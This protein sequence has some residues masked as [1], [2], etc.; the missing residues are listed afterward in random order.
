MATDCAGEQARLWVAERARTPFRTPRA[1]TRQPGS[2][3]IWIPVWVRIPNR[4]PLDFDQNPNRITLNSKYSKDRL[5]ATGWYVP[6]P[7][8]CCALLWMYVAC[9]CPQVNIHHT[10]T[11]CS[12]AFSERCTNVCPGFSVSSVQQPAPST[13]TLTLSPNQRA[14]TQI[15]NL[16]FFHR[17]GYFTAKSQFRLD[18]CLE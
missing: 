13:I 12:W 15:K 1:C 9:L 3:L 7:V 14:N 10:H 8:G 17:P 18:S 5:L 16:F 2:D 11:T 4:N 6:C